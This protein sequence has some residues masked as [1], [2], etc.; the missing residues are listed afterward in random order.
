MRF[1][2]VNTDYGG[3]LRQLYGQ[4]S[5]LETAPYEDQMRARTE[6]LFGVADFYSRNLRR[7]G[8]EAWD[9][10]ANNESMQRAWAREHGLSAKEARPRER[11]TYQ[12]LKRARGAAANTP[13]RHLK[14]VLRPLLHLLDSEQAWLYDVLSAQISHYQPDVLLN[15]NIGLASRFFQEAK[16]HTR[17]LVG[18]HASVVP[19]GQDLS[20]Y[21]LMISSLPN[22]VDYFAQQ[23]V[24]SEL[25]RLGFEPAVLQRLG[26]VKKSRLVSFVGSVFPAHASRRQWLEYVCQRTGV[27]VWGQ[28]NGLPQDSPVVNCHQ[29]TAWGLE[30][31]RIVRGSHMTLNHHIDVAENYANNMR[32]YEA[33]GVGTLLVTDW[34]ENLHEMFD[35]G[36]EVVAYRSPQECVELIEHYSNHREEREAIARRGQQRTLRDH[37]YYERMQELVDIVGRHL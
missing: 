17:L 28:A 7:L 6:S 29:G 15:Q 23:G 1:L 20:V 31:Y 3:F 9:V 22:L 30:M 5:T 26:E 33:T 34:K 36:S 37:T 25:H 32:L 10:Y 24:T 2:I 8:H 27:E 35:P 13:L 19:K 18:Q 12:I 16:P 4:H 21:D 14:P 11:A